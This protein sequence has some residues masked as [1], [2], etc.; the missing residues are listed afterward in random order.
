VPLLRTLPLFALALSCL[1]AQQPLS[2]DDAVSQALASHPLLAEGR[3]RAASARGQ[4]TQAGLAPNPRLVL[5][6][7]NL[8]PQ[9]IPFRENDHFAYLQQTLETAGKRTKRVELASRGLARV[10]LENEILKRQI[11]LRVRQAYWAAAGAA[12]VHALLE[13]NIRTFDQNVTYHEIRVREGAM[14][15]TDLLRVRLE[16]ERL[17]L[18]A[19]QAHLD[20]EKARIQLF[21]EMGSAEF[22]PATLAEPLELSA[23]PPLLADVDDALRQRPEIALARARIDQARAAVA[24]AQSGAKSNLEL[25]GGYKRTNG[26]DTALLGLQTD[27]MLRNRNQGNLESALAEVKMEESALAATQA[28]VRAEVQSARVEVDTRRRQLSEFLVRARR[29]AAEAARIAQAAYRL[30]GTDLLRLL[31]AERLRIEIEVMNCQA[32]TGYRQSLE[33]LRAAMGTSR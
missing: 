31:D 2:L 17:R 25:L 16:A 20:F 12:R 14:A 1:P 3:Q 4:Q 5:Q 32:L 10:E 24:L 8:R 22:P 30:G 9:G 11:E 26:Y 33:S 19:N 13:E 7:E 28:V 18:A 27:L 29:Q 23:D 6:L 21:R 15:E